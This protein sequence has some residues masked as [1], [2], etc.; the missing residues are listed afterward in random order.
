LLAA[1]VYQA[2]ALDPLIL[3]GVALTMLLTGVLSIAGPVRRALGID[4]AQ[5]LREQ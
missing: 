4:P 3:G 1:I 2:S 5:L